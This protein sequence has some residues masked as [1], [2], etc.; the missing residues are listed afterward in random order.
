MLDS[1]TPPFSQER[2]RRAGSGPKP[3]SGAQGLRQGWRGGVPQPRR[4]SGPIREGV[5]GEFAAGLGSQRWLPGSR[6]WEAANRYDWCRSVSAEGAR[7]LGP[8]TDPWPIHGPPAWPVPRC[9]LCEPTEV[10]ATER[11]GPMTRTAPRSKHSPNTARSIGG[12]RTP[13]IAPGPVTKADSSCRI[14][15]CWRNPRRK[16]QPARG[17]AKIPP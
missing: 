8:I 16:P 17:S 12:S 10:Q 9:S 14:Q 6:A 4:T 11:L 2:P 7:A 1:S 5:G 3:L 13:W 15:A